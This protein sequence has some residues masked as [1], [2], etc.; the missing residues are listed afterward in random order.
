MQVNLRAF[1]KLKRE[2]EKADLEMLR[3]VAHTCSSRLP[4]NAL[5]AATV[6]KRAVGKDYLGSR[7]CELGL[8]A[9]LT[10]KRDGCCWKFIG[11]H[12]EV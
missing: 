2:R 8:S 3:H 11:I 9:V 7:C 4:P 10:L 6:A 1:L 12:K 5:P